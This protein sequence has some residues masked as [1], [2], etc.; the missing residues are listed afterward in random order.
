MIHGRWNCSIEVSF[1]YLVR[2][3]RQVLKR[4][5]HGPYEVGDNNY[6]SDHYQRHNDYAYDFKSSEGLQNSQVITGVYSKEL[7][8]KTGDVLIDILIESGAALVIISVFLY[9]SATLGLDGLGNL[10]QLILGHV[11]D[12]ALHAA[13]GQVCDV[14][15]KSLGKVRKSLS[16]AVVLLQ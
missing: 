16:I 6:V 4:H 12:V 10:L 11:A 7:N 5:D 9:I 8:V 13:E 3:I 2:R 1:R 14:V 15:I